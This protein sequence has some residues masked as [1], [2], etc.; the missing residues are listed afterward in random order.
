MMDWISG[1]MDGYL[2]GLQDGQMDGPT[3]EEIRGLSCRMCIWTHEEM[4]EGIDA[5][6]LGRLPRGVKRINQTGDSQHPHNYNE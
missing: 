2:S 4:D 1:L 6:K 5:G 3:N